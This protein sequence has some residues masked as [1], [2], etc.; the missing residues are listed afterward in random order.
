MDR[1]NGQVD[2]WIEAN[3]PIDD[4]CPT[5]R[6]TMEAG[7]LKR[8]AEPFPTADIEWRIQRAGTK[9]DKA[10][11]M[12]LA[13]VTNRAIQDRLDDVCGPEGWRNEFA[14]GPGGGVLCGLSV[15]VGDEW[16]T[17]WDGSDNTDVEAVKG[18]LSGAMK[19]A[20]V[21]WGVGRYLYNLDANWAN[22]HGGGTHYQPKSK[23]GK[24]PAFKWDPPD[25]PA[26]AVPSG[27][28]DPVRR[29]PAPQE[30]KKTGTKKQAKKEKDE[31]GDL[32][33]AEAAFNDA[34]AKVMEAIGEDDADNS[35][36]LRRK[37][38]KATT[39]KSN[40]FLAMADS[41][42]G[43]TAKEITLITAMLT[44]GH[45]KVAG[46]C[47]GPVPDPDDPENEEKATDWRKELGL[48]SL[49]VETC[50]ICNN[51]LT[52][53][54]KASCAIAKLDGHFC[55]K[56]VPEGIKKTQEGKK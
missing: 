30:P 48:P 52:E 8:L 10:W 29:A 14:A 17:K 16:I 43:M 20:A 21:Q 1:L 3:L 37:F 4:T 19:R 6:R 46:L 2:E 15:F 56:H 44:K 11:A 54:E 41:T 12:V 38:F 45:A 33:A 47:A 32:L 49:G 23:E 50:E 5:R 34:W 9:D 55:T 28:P 51:A 18:G 53:A 24:Y 25:L 42:A 39:E 27:E 35:T 36:A 22:V 26:W 7:D 31:T 13:Y 40:A